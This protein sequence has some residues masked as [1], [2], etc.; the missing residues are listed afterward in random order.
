ML[1]IVSLHKDELPTRN[2][3]WRKHKEAIV[4]NYQKQIPQYLVANRHEAITCP[5][6]VV[7]NIHTHEIVMIM[8]V[9]DMM[10][11]YLTISQIFF[12]I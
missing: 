9:Y 8:Q 1:I 4:T 3:S 7:R 10:I 6:Y 12:F 5:N 11:S 2:W